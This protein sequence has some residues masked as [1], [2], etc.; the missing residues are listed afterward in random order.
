MTGQPIQKHCCH[1]G[2]AT[3]ELR[4]YG[5]GGAWVCFPCGMKPE[6]RAMTDAMFGAQLD[7]ACPIVM[8]GEESG[9]RPLARNAS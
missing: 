5:P 3:E 6:N 4:P 1:C 8:I 7:A 9:P 2:S